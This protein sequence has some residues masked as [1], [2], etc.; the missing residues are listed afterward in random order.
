M[1]GLLDWIEYQRAKRRHR[2]GLHL[3]TDWRRLVYGVVGW[4]VMMGLVW[5]AVWDQLRH[6]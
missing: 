5:L 6:R 3:T 1:V 2:R 4:L